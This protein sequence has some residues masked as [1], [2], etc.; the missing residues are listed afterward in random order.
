LGVHSLVVLRTGY[1]APAAAAAVGVGDDFG[2]IQQPTGLR[3]IRQLR[4][5]S[6]EL[7]NVSSELRNVSLGLRNVSLELRNACYTVGAR[8]SGQHRHPL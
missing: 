8:R 7:R 3:A 5:V 4:N 2:L 6:L 1:G